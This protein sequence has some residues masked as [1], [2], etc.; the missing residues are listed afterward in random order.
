MPGAE[1][2]ARIG[3]RSNPRFVELRT[4]ASSAKER[5]TRGQTLLDGPHLVRSY[6]EH[7]GAPRLL[8]VSDDACDHPEV[9]AL[10]EF[11]SGC[12]QL[13]FEHGLF[14]QLAPVDN[15]V[16]ILALVDTPRPGKAQELGELVVML[17][18]IQDPGNVGTIIRAAA[19]ADTDDV[20]LSPGCADAWS[21]RT[22]RAGM[23]AH[24]ALR[25]QTD[26]D[27]VAAVKRFPGI[28]IAAAG[29]DG[30]RPDA[31][32]MRARVAFV[33]GSEGAGLREELAREARLRVSIPM[34]RGIE[35]LNVGAAAAVLL[36]ERVRQLAAL[37]R[38]D[39]PR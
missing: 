18:G 34:A 32:D 7:C 25:V 31:V 19:A 29:V 23:G 1:R 28:A 11:A 20:L 35:S 37:S 21:P 8:A 3:S 38:D 10:L 17:D 2:F 5:R 14:R 27:L 39:A 33:F 13:C 26:V 15:P 4:L 9:A 12:P 24:F 36:F 16:G 6:I 22:L 30:V